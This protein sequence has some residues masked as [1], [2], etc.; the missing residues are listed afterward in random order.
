MAYGLYLSFLSF[1]RPIP[2]FAAILLVVGPILASIVKLTPGNIGLAESMAWMT[3]VM[4]GVHPDQTI[5]AFA[6]FRITAFLYCITLGP[7]FLKQLWKEAV[8]V[9][10]SIEH[11]PLKSAA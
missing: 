6:I 9:S 10:I 3:A 11:P 1:G 8:P 4:I 5:A 2:W 7:F